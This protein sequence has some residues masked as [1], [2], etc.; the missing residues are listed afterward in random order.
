MTN[1][2]MAESPITNEPTLIPP[3]IQKLKSEVVRDNQTGITLTPFN[4][5][6]V[7]KYKKWFSDP[8]VL[9][10]LHLNTPFTKDQSKKVSVEEFIKYICDDPGSAY[11]R[12]EHPEYGFIGHTSLSA[13]N[14]GDM[15]FSLA[16]IIGEKQ[17]WRK[18]IGTVVE[19]M[20]SKRAKELG[21]RTV[22]AVAFPTNEA[23]IKILTKR[24]GRG[25]VEGN[26]VNFTKA[27]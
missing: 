3:V 27:L 6:E 8:E 4:G 25:K 26:L 15:S 19:K 5:S 16:G 10:F 14:L 17:Y 18:S 20:I 1:Q 23:S 7:D 21:F 11:F 12:I 2:F 24:F 13:I 22:K 9:K